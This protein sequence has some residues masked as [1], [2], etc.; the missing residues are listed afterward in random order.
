MKSKV[1]FFASSRISSIASIFISSLAAGLSVFLIA[2]L[3]QWLVYDDWMHKNGPLRFVG[4]VLASAL[5]FAFVYRWKIRARVEKIEMLQRF[6][7]IKWMNDRIRNSLQAIECV[8][9]AF[10]PHVTDPIRDA[11]DNI[12]NVLHEVLTEAHPD[13]VISSARGLA[14]V[15]RDSGS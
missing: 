14:S 11:V 7:R 5:S 15:N 6:E 8:A 2:V 1:E 4:S 10:S 3:L 12:E 9:Y 13:T